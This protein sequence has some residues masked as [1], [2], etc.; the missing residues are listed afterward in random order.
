VIE[1]RMHLQQE[2]LGGLQIAVKS[3]QVFW[4]SSAQ[5]LRK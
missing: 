2:K 3:D 5:I 4:Q 1:Y